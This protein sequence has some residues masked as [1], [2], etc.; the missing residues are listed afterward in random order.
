MRSSSVHTNK[1]LRVT[2]SFLTKYVVGKV[3]F[4]SKS[5]FQASKFFKAL[6]NQH[7]KIT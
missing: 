6:T 1:P 7:S 5:W 3:P 4:E 2:L